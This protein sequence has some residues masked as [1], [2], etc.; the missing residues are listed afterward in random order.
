MA[1]NWFIELGLDKVAAPIYDAVRN[2]A[3]TWG[4][5]AG[6]A[7][8]ASSMLPALRS[9]MMPAAASGVLPALA[10][11]AA[12]A[13]AA[14]GWLSKLLGK[15]AGG[16]MAMGAMLPIGLMLGAYLLSNRGSGQPLPQW[17]QMQGGFEPP[18][19]D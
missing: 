1:R 8:S 16:K 5:P 12:P 6:A 9:S 4:V 7:P 3:G 14:G 13:A 18:Q 10:S 11:K 17:A 19:E 2:A 15:G